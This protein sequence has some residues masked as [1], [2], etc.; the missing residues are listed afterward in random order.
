MVT[1]VRT[2]EKEDVSLLAAAF[3]ACGTNKPV[4]LF[5]R[6]YL[7]Q[8]NRDLVCLVARVDTNDVGYLTVCWS[9]QYPSFSRRGIPE[10]KDL[11]VLPHYRGK[12][13]GARLMAHAEEIIS[14]KSDFAGIGVGLYSGYGIQISEG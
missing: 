2:L 10:I 6:Y 14:E 11:N 12:G 5:E 13:Y 3:S 9:S 7:E 8:Q 4:Q 1:I